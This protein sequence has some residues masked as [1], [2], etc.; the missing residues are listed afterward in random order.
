VI[1]KLL[2]LATIAG[3]TLA[4]IPRPVPL[5]IRWAPQVSDSQ[6]AELERQLTLSN[7]ELREGT[8]RSYVLLDSSRT[9]IEAIV[10]HPSIEDTSNI[11]RA[12]LR[13]LPPFDHTN[14]L[15]LWT[16]VL[17]IAGTALWEVLPFA[18]RRLAPPVNPGS[19]VGFAL[20]GGAPLL[21]MLALT[22]LVVAAVFGL[23]PLWREREMPTLAHAAY[24]ED[25]AL[26]E[27]TREAGGDLDAREAVSIDGRTI[28]VTPIE[29]AIFG[30][31]LQ[32][33]RWLITNG[34]RVD[35]AG[36]LTLRCLAAEVD[37]AD[38]VDYLETLDETRGDR[39]CDGVELPI[40]R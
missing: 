28:T 36:R 20:A 2:L 8:T 25:L 6:R 16:I 32:T 10:R 18:G 4:I 19:G 13:L 15:R 38:I 34:P 24:E 5:N 7:G 14:R 35:A 27:R 37:A 39:S 23:Q 11:D 9:N 3:A 29:A 12:T 17:A 33:V 21:L 22:G 1:V 40:R 30:H 31:S 26:L